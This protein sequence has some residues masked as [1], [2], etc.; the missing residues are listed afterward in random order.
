V[1]GSRLV[2]PPPVHAAAGE[3]DD[4]RPAHW[5]MAAAFVVY[6]FVRTSVLV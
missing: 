2:A 6:Y 1:F 3:T 4:V 5:F